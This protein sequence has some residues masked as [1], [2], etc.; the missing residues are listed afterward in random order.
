MRTEN[1]E[2][3]E[4]NAPRV[5]RNQ[6]AVLCEEVGVHPSIAIEHEPISEALKS[7][8]TVEQLRAILIE[9]F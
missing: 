4:G 6:F 7:G 8:K 1:K 5:T 9:E 2:T 3:G